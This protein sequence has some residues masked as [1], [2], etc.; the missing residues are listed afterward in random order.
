MTSIYILCNL[1]E[2]SDIAQIYIIY[3][4]YDSAQFNQHVSESA[5]LDPNFVSVKLL[6]ISDIFLGLVFF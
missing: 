6:R 1:A 3:I 2:I 4:S 5:K